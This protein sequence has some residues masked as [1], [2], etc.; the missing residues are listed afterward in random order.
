MPAENFNGLFG[1][2]AV[3]AIMALG[4]TG[5]FTAVV[6]YEVADIIHSEAGQTVRPVVKQIAIEPVW[7]DAEVEKAKAVHEVAYKE[8]TGKNQLDWSKLGEKE[9]KKRAD[10]AAGNVTDIAPGKKAQF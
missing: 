9:T 3:E 2:E 10:K 7:E 4:V 6:E 1:D 8:R 5:R